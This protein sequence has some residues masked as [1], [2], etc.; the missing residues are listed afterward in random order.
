MEK[1]NGK[2]FERRIL[3]QL[4]VHVKGLA[5]HA[6]RYGVQG[7]FTKDS[8]T[9]QL[10]WRPIQSLP[11]F[12]GVLPPFGRQFVFDAKVCSGASFPLR[13]DKFE[14]RQKKHLYSR[15]RMGCITFLLIHFQER[16]LKKGTQESLTVAFPVF[17]EHSFWM[18]VDSGE[19]KRISRSDAEIYGVP[20]EW[21]DGPGR[22][23]PLILEAVMRLAERDGALVA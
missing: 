20:V 18:R 6:G 17:P 12:E 19:E 15:S 22:P 11:D 14:K 5:C 23:R 9:G 1:I 10:N 3:Y 8:A 4:D 16:E 7:V 13:D 21:T 2:E